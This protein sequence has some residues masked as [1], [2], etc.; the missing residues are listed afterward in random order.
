VPKRTISGKET[1]YYDNKY[2]SII[3]DKDLLNLYEYMM[4]TLSDLK[5]LIPSFNKDLMQDNALPNIQ[6]SIVEMYDNE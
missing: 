1:G 5:L 6:A 2:N 3:N 4:D